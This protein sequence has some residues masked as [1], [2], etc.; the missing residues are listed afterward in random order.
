VRDPAERLL[1]PR[2]VAFVGGSTAPAALQVCRDRG[3]TGTIRYVHPRA[4][5]AYRSVSDLPEV[6]DAAYLAIPAA[7]TIE[8]VRELAAIGAGGAVCYAAGFSEVGDDALEQALVDAAG[9]MPFLGPNCFGLIDLVDDV[10]LWPVPYPQ[11]RVDRGVAFVLQSGNLGINL[12][13]ADRSLPVSFVVSVGNQAGLDVAACIATLARQPEVSAI[14]V[15]LEGIRDLAAFVDAAHVAA[16]AD[17]PIVVVKAGTSDLGARLTATHTASLAGADEL[18]D[19]LF[20]RLAIA[21][22]PSIPAMLEGL[23]ALTTVRRLAGRR[24]AI[25]TCSGGESALAAD[26]A[27][28]AGLELP[29]LSPAAAAT[30]AADLPP[31][32]AV[33]NPLDYNTALWGLEEPLTRVFGAALGDDVD[34]GLLVIDHQWPG[35]VV[36]GGVAAAIRAF[37]RAGA[38]LG[39]GLAVASTVPESFPTEVRDALYARGVAPLQ[40]LPEA[41]AALAA[42]ARRGGAP[43]GDVLAPS[44]APATSRLRDEVESK[45]ALTAAGIRIPRGEHVAAGGAAAAA[46]RVGFP[47]VVKLVSAAI[48]HKADVG[49]IRLGLRSPAEVEEAVAAMLV[50]VGDVP[51]DGVL[52]EEMVPGAVAELLVGVKRDPTFGPVLVVGTGGG[53]VEVIADARPVL[54]PATREQVAEALGHLRGWRRIVARGDVPAAIEAVVALAAWACERSDVLVGLDVNPLLVLAPGQGVVAVDALL[55]CGGDEVVIGSR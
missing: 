13:M 17:V 25:A 41:L 5:G 53:L 54:L 23:K 44:P 28:V 4:E 43:P 16:A 14:G 39:I 20:E 46:Q 29:P 12:T 27:S 36:D 21:R 52:V 31:Y 24:L 9:A 35:L 19:A 18:Y 15:Y 26:A 11:R 49:A 22:S 3:F 33:G 42:C 8:V 6:P 7:A 38:G 30:I 51:V 47:V 32:A 40:G 1:R 34:G 37:E 10:A 2:S 45:R 48:P 50:A 55:E